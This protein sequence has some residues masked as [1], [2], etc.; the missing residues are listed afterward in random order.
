MDTPAQPQPPQVQNPAPPPVQPQNPVSPSGTPGTAP[1]A[2]NWGRFWASFT[3]SVI[4]GIVGGVILIVVAFLSKT[5]GNAGHLSQTALYIVGVLFIL[6]S[7]IY[8]VYFT[9]T[10]GATIGKD[11]YGFKVYRATEDQTLTYKEALLRE[12]VLAVIGLIPFVSYLL[13]TVNDLFILMTKLGIHDRVAHT[14]VAKVNPVWPMKKQL[15]AFI[16]LL[17]VLAVVYTAFFMI[18]PPEELSKLSR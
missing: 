13:I 16:L 6:I 7:L 4:V 2:G 5:T 1:L 3:D 9:V 17:L 14:R 11:L 10:K 12:G 15:P 8:K 18:V